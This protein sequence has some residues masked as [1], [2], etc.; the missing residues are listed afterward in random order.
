M[1]FNQ[2][3]VLVQLLL[4]IEGFHKYLVYTQSYIS[5]KFNGATQI[6]SSA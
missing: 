6:F 2:S 1:Q 4:L 3:T 5:T